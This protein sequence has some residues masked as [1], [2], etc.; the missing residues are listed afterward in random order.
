[1]DLKTYEDIIS[2]LE[3]DKAYNIEQGNENTAVLY[4]YAIRIVKEHYNF[5]HSEI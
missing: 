1:M 4:A 2:L 5:I 3:Q